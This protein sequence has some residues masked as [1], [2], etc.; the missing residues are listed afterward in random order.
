MRMLTEIVQATVRGIGNNDVS[1]IDELLHQL[2][3]AK[4]ATGAAV[5]GGT[6]K[7]PKN[8]DQLAAFGAMDAAFHEQLG[9][10]VTAS[11][12]NDVPGA[13]EALSQ[14]VKGCPGCHATFRP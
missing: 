11:S 6:Y 1:G 8:P 9:A 7:L 14:I 3:A 5:K 12:K 10:L 13:A 2:H 4:E